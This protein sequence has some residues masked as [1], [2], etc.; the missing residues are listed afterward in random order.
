MISYVLRLVDW[1]SYS[2]VGT[3]RDQDLIETKEYRDWD[4]TETLL[5]KEKLQ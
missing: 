1:L 4:Q 3:N 2:Q 5:I